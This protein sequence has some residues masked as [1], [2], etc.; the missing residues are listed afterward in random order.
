M[1]RP[2]LLNLKC[3]GVG[4][5][6]RILF[7]S[8]IGLVGASYAN[9]QII[10]GKVTD[11]SGEPLVGVAVIVKNTITGAVTNLDGTYTIQARSA[12]AVLDFS[13]L[14]YKKVSEKVGTRT[15]INVTLE[16]D[17]QQLEEVVVVGYGTKKK[18]DLT[19]AVGMVNA[20]AME[21]EQPMTVQDLLR[22]SVPGLS[23]GIAS[24]AKGN[25]TNM[26]IRGTNNFRSGDAA[27]APLLVLDG[28]IY[29]GELTD[30]NP[31]DVERIDVLKDGSSAAIY[32]SKSANGVILITTKKGRLGKPV[33]RFSSTTGLSIKN[34]MPSTYKGEDYARFRQ[35]VMR[36]I[37]PNSM[38]NFYDDPRN[39]A[40][41]T[42]L[43]DW[44]NGST[45]DPVMEWLTRLG[46]SETEKANYI[47]GKFVDWEKLTYKNVAVQQDYSVSIS[48]R[49]DETSYY[50]SLNYVDNKSNVRGGGF[51]A[52][53]ARFNLESKATNFLTYGL[54]AQFTVRDEGYESV[55]S[56]GYRNAS[57]YGSVYNE[58]GT[59]KRYPS[60]HNVSLNPLINAHYKDV[61]K[62]ISVLNASMFLKVDLPYGFSVQTTYTPR[63]M[64]TENFVHQGSGNPEWEGTIENKIVREH[65]KNK[66]WQWDN[67]LKWNMD[68]GK[69]SFD[70][71]YLMNWERNEDWNNYIIGHTF[72]PNDLLGYHGLNWA[73]VLETNKDYDGDSRRQSNALMARLHYS[74]D[75]KYMVTASFRRDGDAAF[76][77]N[78]KYSNFPSIAL[79]WAFTEENFFPETEWFNY[80]KL[81]LSYG[82]NGSRGIGAYDAL[83]RVEA[84]KYYYGNLD[85][86]LDYV[87]TYYAY[88]MAN[89]DMKW[90]ST[91]IYNLGVDFIA[92]KNRLSGSVDIYKKKTSDLLLSRELP[93]V[94]GYTSVMSNVGEVQNSGIELLLTSRNI[95]HK[96]FTWE[97]TFSLFYNKNR[98]NSLY[99]VIDPSTGKEADD[100]TNKRFIGKSMFEIWDYKVLG[101]W[102]EWESDEA[103]RFGCR[104]GDFKVDKKD[105]STTTYSNE[106]KRFLGVT[107]PRTRLTMK[108]TF[109]FAN[110][111]TF[112]F[113]MYSY[114]GYY[115]DFNRAK[116]D[117]SGN[118]TTNQIKSKYWTPENQSNSYARLGSKSVTSF[119]V[120]RKA[121]FVRLENISLGYQV[122][123]KYIEPLKIQALNVNVSAK[124]LCVLS[125]W[126]GEDP[127]G[128]DR[129][130]PVMVYFGVNITF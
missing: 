83:M 103:A 46:F 70:F 17:T 19:G 104:P 109:N 34:K 11:T 115:K 2:I 41:N 30:I 24:D 84:R 40:S 1:K 67:M 127:E 112:S 107:E 32:G 37:E 88:R 126:P 130:T 71:T 7:L 106:D 61:K 114:L 78:N 16:E 111:I 14:G 29:Y 66:S 79:A 55:S 76:G 113:N 116:N 85:G 87:N 89:K 110:G 63:F 68:F 20:E 49:K 128:R 121:D 77:E 9:A 59:L 64:W 13:I 97:T 108:N 23:M 43:I 25:V 124:N 22:T 54:N 18:K 42:E 44:L 96:A 72:E 5:Y 119:S 26:T 123:K 6:L 62:D 27:K 8:L 56:T 94:I 31:N 10:T 15:V 95:I 92:L 120:Y 117:N 69:H 36:T 75:N 98:I 35:D 93:P 125:D 57:P 81:R 74:Y 48:G 28:A 52:I 39:F 105:W 102:Q 73:T 100:V 12:E 99:G 4:K 101:V 21:K 86:N 65:K 91:K 60:D 118:K 50:T 47:D 58:D 122:P 53:R 129:N 38:N 80:G 3:N 51:S 90:E 45:E 33:I 82:Q